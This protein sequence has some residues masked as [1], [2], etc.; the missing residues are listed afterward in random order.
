MLY[1]SKGSLPPDPE[2]LACSIA[3]EDAEHEQGSL[4]VMGREALGALGRARPGLR[5]TAAFIQL[6]GSGSG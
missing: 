2:S 5:E 6:S 1:V 3:P 4:P